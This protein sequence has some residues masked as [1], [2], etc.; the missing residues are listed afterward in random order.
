MNRNLGEPLLRWKEANYLER[1]ISNRERIALIRL[2]KSD[3]KTHLLFSADRNKGS[4]E[5]IFL[6]L[7]KIC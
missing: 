6:Y 7:L 4:A 3:L 1:S 2:I 5:K